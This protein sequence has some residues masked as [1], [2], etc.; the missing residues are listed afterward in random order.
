MKTVTSAI[1]INGGASIKFLYSD[2]TSAI[3][4]KTSVLTGL[5]GESK[6]LLDTAIS[7]LTA[8]MTDDKEIQLLIATAVPNND[9]RMTFASMGGYTKIEKYSEIYSYVQSKLSPQNA[10]ILAKADYDRI[11]QRLAD[12]DYAML[13]LQNNLKNVGMAAVVVIAAYTGGAAYAAVAEAGATGVAGAALAEETTVTIAT[14]AAL[15]EAAAATVAEATGTALVGETVSALGF[16]ESIPIIGPVLDKAIDT[17][18]MSIPQRLLAFVKAPAD[19]MHISGGSSPGLAVSADSESN[20]KYFLI[21]L[22]PILVAGAL[23]FNVF[24]RSK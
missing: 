22:V 1:E 23:I 2:G 21:V 24:K 11:Q 18:V 7:K 10:A 9:S 8:V 15:T 17:A 12:E 20:V 14:E 16:V 5:S 19:D 13:T 4:P 3:I 6:A